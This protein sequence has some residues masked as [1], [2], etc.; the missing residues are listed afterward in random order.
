MGRTCRERAG[1]WCVPRGERGGAGG[2]EDGP[3]A[4]DRARE[5]QGNKRREQDAV[6]E[7]PAE[8]G[9]HR[10]R[11]RHERGTE[12]Y[13]GRNRERVTETEKKV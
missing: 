4:G 2:A 12:R 11:N 10:K 6:R 3:P 5:R 7:S 1:E 9:G 13:R 8:Q